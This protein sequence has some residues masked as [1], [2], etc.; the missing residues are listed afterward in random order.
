VTVVHHPQLVLNTLYKLSVPNEATKRVAQRLELCKMAAAALQAR[1][2]VVPAVQLLHHVL[3]TADH[4]PMVVSTSVIGSS[5]AGSLKSTVQQNMCR[6]ED[7]ADNHKLADETLSE[8]S[9]Y[10]CAARSA[11]LARGLIAVAD[12]GAW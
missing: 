6:A 7:L 8:L 3:F 4:S 2:A 10:K 12:D 1:T 11:A 5:T 9:E